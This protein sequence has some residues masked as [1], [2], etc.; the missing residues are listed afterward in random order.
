PAPRRPNARDRRKSPARTEQAGRKAPKATHDRATTPAGGPRDAWKPTRPHLHCPG[1][2]S[3][4]PQ[5]GPASTRR[6]S[7]PGE[8]LGSAGKQQHH[9]PLARRKDLRK[10]TWRTPPP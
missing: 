9:R 1:E 5:A 8:L 7:E 10:P 6:A 4:Q 3:P 2:E